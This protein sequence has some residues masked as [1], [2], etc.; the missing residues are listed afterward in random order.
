MPYQGHLPGRHGRPWRS[1]LML[2]AGAAVACIL[3]FMAGPAAFAE[4]APTPV[5]EA[6]APLDLAL[7][8]CLGTGHTAI[9]ES[10]VR[11]QAAGWT[12]AAPGDRGSFVTAFAPGNALSRSAAMYVFTRERFGANFRRE[13]E[14]LQ[15]MIQQEDVGDDTTR[16]WLRLPG[17]ADSPTAHLA[18]VSLLQRNGGMSIECLLAPGREGAED[19]IAAR[20]ED[21]AIP[22]DTDIG[23]V[24][25]WN[26]RGVRSL[27]SLMR[28]ARSVWVPP[29]TLG[30]SDLV[31]IR[32]FVPPAE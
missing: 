21:E 29:D 1:Q 17:D 10:L 22:F 32:T 12:V 6:I 8:A 9:D 4:T 25:G 5:S 28:P 14:R 30:A 31:N 11:L 13:A 26:A 23:L 3:A 19:L 16:L 7:D 2:R 18:L 20:R 24:I 15:R 27:I